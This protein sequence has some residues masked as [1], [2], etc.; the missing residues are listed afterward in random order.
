MNRKLPAFG[1]REHASKVFAPYYLSRAD[2]SGE[3]SSKREQLRSEKHS[4]AAKAP[5]HTD[6]NARF[7]M[8]YS[9][10]DQWFDQH[11]QRPTT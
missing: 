4:S 10:N 3:A 8:T 1:A 5:Q 2:M 6:N 9:H 7:T 11:H